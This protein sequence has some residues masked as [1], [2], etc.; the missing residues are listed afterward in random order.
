LNQFGGNA[1]VAATLLDDA[2]ED[3]FWYQAPK[4]G[5]EN[6]GP[7]GNVGSSGDY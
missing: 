6:F 1:Q 3:D 7:A 5:G 2:N 4:N